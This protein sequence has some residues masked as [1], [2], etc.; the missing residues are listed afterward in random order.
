MSNVRADSEWRTPIS[1]KRLI[2]TFS[3]CGTVFELLAFLLYRLLT[4]SDVIAISPLGGV[5][6][7]MFERILNGLPRFPISV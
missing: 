6:C 4:R 1:Y 5:E 3:V 7:Q 2:V